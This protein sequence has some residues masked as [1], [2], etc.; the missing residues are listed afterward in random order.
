MGA[1][2]GISWQLQPE[3]RWPVRTF[4]QLEPQDRG[5]SH[6]PG[7][8]QWPGAHGRLLS[9]DLVLR[10]GQDV[11]GVKV[12]GASQSL[13]SV[14]PLCGALWAWAGAPWPPRQRA[15]VLWLAG[16]TPRPPRPRPGRE[17]ACPPASRETQEQSPAGRMPISSHPSGDGLDPLG[18]PIFTYVVGLSVLATHSSGQG[19][20]CHW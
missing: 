8:Q 15:L 3:A 6:P 1:D 9:K 4:Q 10:A 13:L 19:G 5:G 16:R 2:A 11:G 12:V 14:L 7:R 17:H 20:R 18:S